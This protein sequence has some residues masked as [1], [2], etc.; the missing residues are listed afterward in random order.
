MQFL[1]NIHDPEDPNAKMYLALSFE[2][3]G[4]PQG[5]ERAWQEHLDWLKDKVIGEPQ[6]TDAYTSDQL[7]ELGMV[8]VYL[9]EEPA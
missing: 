5:R 1:T 3:M 8:G 7:K 9:D 6:G 4:N 2:D